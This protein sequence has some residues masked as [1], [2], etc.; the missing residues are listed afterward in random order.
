M[1]DMKSR[2]THKSYLRIMAQEL[3][4]SRRAILQAS[5]RA[6]ARLHDPRREVRA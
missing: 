2:A 5:A 6:A 4:V 1:I 3:G